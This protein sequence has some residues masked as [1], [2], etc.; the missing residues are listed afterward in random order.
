MLYKIGYCAIA[1]VPV[2]KLIIIL[3]ILKGVMSFNTCKKYH[4]I[5]RV[6]GIYSQIL[7]FK[8]A[9]FLINIT[10]GKLNYII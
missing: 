1:L 8:I 3:Y 10:L 2:T 4:I 9:V 5:F 7:K 6:L